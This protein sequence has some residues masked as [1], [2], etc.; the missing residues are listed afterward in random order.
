MS[1]RL[2][3]GRFYGTTA[4]RIEIAGFRFTEKSYGPDTSLPR[5]SHELSHFC[6]VVEGSY[7]EW[8]R[9]RTDYR[10]PS[11]LV[12]YPPDVTHAESHAVNGRHFLVELDQWRIDSLREADVRLQHPVCF[13][14]DWQ[15]R[16]A[17]RL[18]REFRWRD[19]VTPLLL[20]G[21]A[22]ELLGGVARATIKKPPAPPPWLVGVK[23]T[24]DAAFQS[25]PALSELA[26][27][28]GVHPVHLARTFRQF[29]KCTI[30]DYIRRLR[31]DFACRNIVEGR[32][33]LVEIALAAGFADQAHF[34]KT[35][36]RLTGMTPSSFRKL[37]HGC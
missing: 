32:L 33:P 22:L 19:S 9:G 5:H 36:R 26:S 6:F 20:E 31:I 13:E 16:L 24:L 37:H 10:R 3:A 28:A 23:E 29:E 11:M 17:A 14:G 7:S 2:E 15:C 1:L 34:S 4:A 35:F 8:L 18:Y 30:G 12:F 27:Q 21:L 25:S